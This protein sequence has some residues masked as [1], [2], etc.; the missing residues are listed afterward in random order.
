MKIEIL[1]KN[2]VKVSLS[3]ED[4]L[5]YNLKPEHL[6]PDSPQL[7]KFLFQIM[8]NV[9]RET[10]FNPHNGQV[11]VEATQNSEGITLIIS[12]LKHVAAPKKPPRSKVKSIRPVVH[13]KIS[14]TIVY[15]FDQF[16]H[17]CTA[18]SHIQKDTLH[19][20]R[21][22]AYEKSFYL[23]S[24][25][26]HGPQQD[27]FAICEFCSSYGNGVYEEAFVREHGSCI[28]AG[29]SLVS[30]ADGIKNL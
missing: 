6:T 11:V 26:G 20:S 5:I 22:Y 14:E 30:M 9:E 8:E 29:P 21:L 17:L 25:Y 1:E 2:K 18:L 10:G 4:L 28:A 27:H 3:M 12:K 16:E 7:H 24:D 19:G 13:S 15:R 23:V